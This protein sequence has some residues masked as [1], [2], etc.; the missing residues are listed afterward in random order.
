MNALFGLQDTAHI[1]EGTP[2]QLWLKK[3]GMRTIEKYREL[4]KTPGG[5]GPIQFQAETPDSV[6]NAN[7]DPENKFA[8]V[9][10]FS[11]VCDFAVLTQGLLQ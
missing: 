4:L 9:D 5:I 6:F 10:K 3:H 2:L 1:H 11:Q 7:I 8:A